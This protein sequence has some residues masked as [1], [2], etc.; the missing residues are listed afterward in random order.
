MGRRG[1]VALAVGLPKWLWPDAGVAEA[2]CALL[3]LAR[4]QLTGLTLPT[5]SLL[6]HVH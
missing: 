5:R 3:E 2:A 1:R 4:G 6:P